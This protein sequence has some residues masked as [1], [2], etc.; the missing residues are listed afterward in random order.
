MTTDN[1]RAV[2]NLARERA[3]DAEADLAEAAAERDALRAEL[4]ATR[5]QL[6]AETLRLVAQ[7]RIVDRLRAGNGA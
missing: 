1:F 6:R 2:L 5:D 7:W 3:E 4:A